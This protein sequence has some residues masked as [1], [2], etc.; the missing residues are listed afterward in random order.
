ML[1]KTHLK[2]EQN[3]P[4]FTVLVSCK[5]VSCVR[6]DLNLLKPEVHQSNI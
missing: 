5:N 4:F 6:Y 3:F 2:V 1:H